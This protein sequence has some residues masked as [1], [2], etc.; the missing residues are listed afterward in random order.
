MSFIRQ[1]L[2]RFFGRITSF[3]TPF[4]GVSWTPSEQ[5]RKVVQRVF[6]ELEAKRVLFKSAYLESPMACERSVENIRDLLTKEIGSL[7]RANRLEDFLRVMRDACN[8]FLNSVQ[9]NGLG[10]QRLSNLS[11]CAQLD[12][13][14]ALAFLRRDFGYGIANLADTCEIQVQGDISRIVPPLSRLLKLPLAH[15]DRGTT[16]H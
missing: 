12:F 14:E 9:D 4:G 6:A 1:Q 11:Q 8:D 7:S 3:S 15:S 2:S 13:V 10:T 5:E 16:S